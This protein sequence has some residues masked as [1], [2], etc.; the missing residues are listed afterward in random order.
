MVFFFAILIAPFE[1]L[2]ERITGKSRGVIPIAIATANVNAVKDS[3]FQA[4]KINTIGIII[5]INLIRSLLIFLIL[6]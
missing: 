6:F 1:R 2:D 5:T 4:V 3:C